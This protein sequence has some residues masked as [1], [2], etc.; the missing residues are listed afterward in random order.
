MRKLYY[1]PTRYETYLDQLGI[2]Y[3]DVRAGRPGSGTER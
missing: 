1:D 3:P 2:S